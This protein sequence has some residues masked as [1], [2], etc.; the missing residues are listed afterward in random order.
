MDLEE[1]KNFAPSNGEKYIFVENGKPTVVLLSFEDY[2]KM[3][4]SNLQTQGNFFQI[5]EARVQEEGQDEAQERE[6]LKEEL[7][8][9]LKEGLTLEDLP[10]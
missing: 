7:R 2:K 6:E 1:I 3:S 5:K 9:E 8:Q 4:S 10:F